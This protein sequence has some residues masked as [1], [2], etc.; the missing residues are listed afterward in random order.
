[1][2][3]QCQRKTKRCACWGIGQQSRPKG[4][5]DSAFV[6]ARNVTRSSEH[7]PRCPPRFPRYRIFLCD[8]PHPTEWVGRVI[9]E[10]SI[11][12]R[13][14]FVGLHQRI[15]VFCWYRCSSIPFGLILLK[16]LTH[17]IATVC[18]LAPFVCLAKCRAYQSGRHR[19][20]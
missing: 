13:V 15:R 4:C 14:I 16:K 8:Q 1:M 9:D 12:R 20:L 7:T 11:F 3:R 5:L 17:A 2:H 18:I 19:Q 6:C 10:W